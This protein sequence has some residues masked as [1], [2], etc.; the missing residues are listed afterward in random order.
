VWAVIEGPG[1]RIQAT[2]VLFGG[3]SLLVNADLLGMT[4]F[5]CFVVWRQD[6]RSNHDVWRHVESELTAPRAPQDGTDLSSC[7]AMLLNKIPTVK[8]VL[9]GDL[10][11]LGVHL[12]RV[13]PLH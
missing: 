4:V 8:R 5:D 12:G 1:K 11:V 10:H 7:S 2:A 9:L 3:A 6:V 13:S